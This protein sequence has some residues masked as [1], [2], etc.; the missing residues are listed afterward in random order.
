MH[1]LTTSSCEGW[2]DLSQDRLPG[3]IDCHGRQYMAKTDRKGTMIE[4][5]RRV[6]VC[7]WMSE[8]WAV[9]S[10][11]KVHTAVRINRIQNRNSIVP[12]R[13]QRVARCYHWRVETFNGEGGSAHPR[14]CGREA[15]A[16][17]NCVESLCAVVH[18]FCRI[19]SNSKNIENPPSTARRRRRRR[20]RRRLRHQSSLVGS[21]GR[22]VLTRVAA[23]TANIK[24]WVETEKVSR[25]HPAECSVFPRCTHVYRPVECDGHVEL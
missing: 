3:K 21:T 22:C 6:W 5:G 7:G 12:L 2:A 16:S 13:Y 19:H 25:R 1:Q 18:H 9:H 15:H 4:K 8:S 20:V 17:I 11:H 14:L 23:A 24:R 10:Q